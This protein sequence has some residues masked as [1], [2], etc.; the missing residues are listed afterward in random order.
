MIHPESGRIGTRSH[1]TR[2][3]VLYYF[4]CSAASNA[5]SMEYQMRCLLIFS[6]RHFS[7]ISFVLVTNQKQTHCVGFGPSRAEVEK[8]SRQGLSTWKKYRFNKKSIKFSISEKKLVFTTKS[9]TKCLK[10]TTCS[11]FKLET[12]SIKF[13]LINMSWQ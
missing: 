10:C 9:K 7:L 12:R 3:F 2:L 5:F 6:S 4:Y 13:Y 8:H 1:V 11:F